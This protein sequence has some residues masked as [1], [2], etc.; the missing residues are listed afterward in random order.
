MKRG[1][2]LS[3]RVAVLGCG[4]WGRTIVRDLVSLGCHVVAVDPLPEARAAAI[5]IGAANAVPTRTELEAV[6]GAIVATPTERHAFD[7]E[8]LLFR[9]IPIFVEMPF[10]GDV[11]SAARLSTFARV[12]VMHQWRYH[13]GIEALR[14]IADSGELGQIVGLRSTR[15][16][17]AGAADGGDIIS[18]LA[19][20]DFA[21]ACAVLG[22]VPALPHVV[23]EHVGDRLTA[24]T[25]MYGDRPWLT[26]D[27]GTFDVAPR[28]DVRVSF[29]NGI[30]LLRDP[31]ADHIEVMR[32]SSKAAR[33]M[34]AIET[35]PISTESPLLRE[36]RVFRD[37]L[38]GKPAPPTT[39][40]EGADVVSAL[41][42]LRM[43]AAVAA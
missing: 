41:A 6:D 15:I 1:S 37:H 18:N 14:A 29:T 13:A 7:V 33:G 31:E 2:T 39:A 38:K 24:L 32:L 8:S 40:K 21:V 27:V 34:K 30:A 23:T 25:A 20:H 42:G 10:T 43:L 26:I 22:E 19:A 12:F 35:R 9:E 36:L 4:R 11:V 3:P 28:F 17:F 5:A 16:D